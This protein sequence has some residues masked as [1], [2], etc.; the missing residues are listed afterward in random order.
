MFFDKTEFCISIFKYTYLIAYYK[1][2]IGNMISINNLFFPLDN[3]SLVTLKYMNLLEVQVTRSGLSEEISMHP[4]SPSM[5]AI[6]DIL[7]DY[8]IESY[9]VRVDESEFMNLP[10]PFVTLIE[11]KN[12]ESFFTVVKSISSDVVEYLDPRTNRWRT[13]SMPDFLK[14]W[15]GT[16]LIGEAKSSA[17]ERKYKQNQLIEW[18]RNLSLQVSLYLI[19][20]LASI[21]VVQSWIVY[22][23]S[24]LFPIAYT[25]ASLVGGAVGLL[26]ILFEID[27][28][29]PVLKNVCSGNKK[30]NCNSILQSKASTFLGV[31]LSLIGFSYFSG[32]LIAL[33]VGGIMKPELLFI[34]SWLSIASIPFIIYSLYYQWRVAKQWCVLCLWVQCILAIQAI[35]VYASGNLFVKLNYI[36]V[37]DVILLVTTFSLVFISAKILL[38]ALLKAKA[39]KSLKME[40]QKFKY[41]P[42]VFNALLSK[43]KFATENLEGLGIFLGNPN[44]RNKIVKICNP[45]C[46]PCAKAHPLIGELLQNNPEIG[47]QIVFTATNNEK[48]KKAEP[49]RHLLAIAENENEHNLKQ[50]LD[51]WYNAPN[52]DYEVFASK[53]KVNGRLA[54]QGSKLEEMREWCDKMKISFTPTYFINGYQLPEIYSLYDLKYFLK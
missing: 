27:Q 41:D 24:A 4:D 5:L 37:Q 29:N 9:A 26:L 28:Y 51:D 3:I 52:K 13:Y 53:Y 39:G 43:Q 34:L 46:G 6:S 2:R 19:P 12:K 45:Y 18:R 31:K 44:A 16:V 49:V 10:F 22:G 14:I 48:D 7:E 1:F 25:I 11:F 35:L 54:E 30:T 20:F 8:G 50:A 47:V 40:L 42:Q 32:A 17:G 36:A 33:L 21:A 23:S 38:P 15:S